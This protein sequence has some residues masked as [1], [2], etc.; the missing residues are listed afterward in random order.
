MSMFN[1][2]YIISILSV[3]WFKNNKIKVV[4]SLQ[5]FTC[6]TREILQCVIMAMWKKLYLNVTTHLHIFK[7]LNIPIDS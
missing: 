2:L 7:S 5:S 3:I 6:H 1:K 4:M